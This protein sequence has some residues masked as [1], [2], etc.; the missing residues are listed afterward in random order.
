MKNRDIRLAIAGAG[1]K[2]WEIAAALGIT[3][4]YF[5]RK[6]RKEFSPEEKARVLKIVEELKG[7]EEVNG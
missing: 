4:S 2:L 1:L 7:S 6:L 3:D 5:S